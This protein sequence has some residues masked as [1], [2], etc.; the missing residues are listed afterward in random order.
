M[1]ADDL[2]PRLTK[3][4]KQTGG[5][6]SLCPAHE[7]HVHSLSIKEEGDRVL[8]HCFAGCT[9]ESVVTAL[10]L[11]MTDLFLKPLE[12]PPPI[13]PVVYVL[14]DTSNRIVAFHV[15]KV[16]DGRKQMFWMRRTG[17]YGLDGTPVASLPLFGS[18]NIRKWDTSRPVFITEGEKDAVALLEHGYRALGTV[19][20]ASSCPDLAV[21]EPLRGH[22]VILWGDN[23]EPGQEHML[24]IRRLL[25]KIAA[26]LFWF[27]GWPDAPPG[28]GASD[29]FLNADTNDLDRVIGA[30]Y[31]S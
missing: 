6:L 3:V 10:E 30:L 13:K 27:E 19:C 12:P 18:H 8:V 26:K 21:L 29:Y 28:A 11:H 16:I 23:D 25:Q 5:W 4:K 20:G 7:D 17:E 9:T 22:D 24:R 31:F 15:R 14:R 2:L 1:R